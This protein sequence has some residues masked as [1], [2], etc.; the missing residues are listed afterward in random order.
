[1][2]RIAFLRRRHTMASAAGPA[3]KVLGL[4]QGAD[5][6]ALLLRARERAR[7]QGVAVM[8]D[9]GGRKLACSV[10]A[11]RQAL[12]QLLQPAQ[13]PSGSSQQQHDLQLGL[14]N[15]S[16]D[17]SG[18]GAFEV[19]VS[20]MLQNM[21]V[22][23]GAR[24]AATVTDTL[25]LSMPGSHAGLKC[26]GCTFSRSARAFSKG[27]VSLPA[28]EVAHAHGPGARVSLDGCQFSLFGPAAV[29]S[30]GGQVEAYGCQA[31][32][33]TQPGCSGHN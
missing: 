5:A 9:L 11:V 19:H 6:A 16:L 1:M 24:P 7:Q 23:C 29:A 33:Q 25:F 31:Q 15:G 4:A 21:E 27:R 30:A 2:N 12:Q 3:W 14:R 18:V 28:V 13:Q 26:E 22:T 10:P 17:M 20:F 32:L 8:V